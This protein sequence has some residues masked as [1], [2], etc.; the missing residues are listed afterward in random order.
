[1]TVHQFNIVAEQVPRP[2]KLLD[3]HVQCT[4]YSSTLHSNFVGYLAAVPYPPKLLGYYIHKVTALS[5]SAHAS[6]LERFTLTLIL[7]YIK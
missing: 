1:M 3:Y 5:S 4:L 2:P 6:V 7:L